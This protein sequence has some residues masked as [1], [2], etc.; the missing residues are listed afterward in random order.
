MQAGRRPH[1]AKEPP[2]R[3][4]IPPSRARFPTCVDPTGFEPATSGMPHRC[5]TNCATGPGVREPP[6]RAP[7][8]PA[9]GSTTFDGPAR[10]RHDRRC[11][12]ITILC[13]VFWGTKTTPVPDRDG[14]HRKRVRLTAPPRAQ[15]AAAHRGRAA[16]RVDRLVPHHLGLLDLW[17]LAEL[18]V[19]AGDPPGNRIYQPPRWGYRRG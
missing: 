9:G 8:P 7:G 4:S 13:G 15:P 11:R 6:D 2:P 17:V 5:A 18:K 3:L 14:R 12:P 10:R 16:R 19:G 1:Q